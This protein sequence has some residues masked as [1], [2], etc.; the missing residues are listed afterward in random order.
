MRIQ[1][2][3]LVIEPI[4]SQKSEAKESVNWFESIRKILLA[5]ETR[6]ILGVLLICV[7][8]FVFFAM[9]SHFIYGN[10][11]Q[12]RAEAGPGGGTGA[13]KAA[14]W[15][16]TL[17][18][19]ISSVLIGRGA[20]FISLTFPILT[21]AIGYSILD[22]R[23]FPWSLRFFM[24]L[25]FVAPWVMLFGGFLTYVFKLQSPDWGGAIGLALIEELSL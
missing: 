21:G 16:G 19:W 13:E 7:S 17:G 20:G 15:L 10:I 12:D 23:V 8:A 14:N 24:I 4:S 5:E 18:A 2:E 6:K 11:D 1:D 3:E 9:V 22:K 25:I